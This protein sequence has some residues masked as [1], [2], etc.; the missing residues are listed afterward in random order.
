MT[1]ESY[2]FSE[3]YIKHCKMRLKTA[4]WTTAIGI[5][6][7]ALGIIFDGVSETSKNAARI[8][9]L[10]VVG[11]AFVGYG[12]SMFA[13]DRSV[14]GLLLVKLKESEEGKSPNESLKVSA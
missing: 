14:M 9:L 11:G 3:L 1:H 12:I 6:C 4:V 13:K 7:I 8:V 5:I 10:N 2:T